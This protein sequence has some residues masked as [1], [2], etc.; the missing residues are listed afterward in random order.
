MSGCCG[1]GA[2]GVGECCVWVGAVGVGAVGGVGVGVGECCGCVGGLGTWV[3]WG[4]GDVWLCGCVGVWVMCVWVQWLRH[5]SSCSVSPT[6]LSF[7]FF[8]FLG[9]FFSQ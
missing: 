1:V 5:Y 3:F 6:F 2:V 9:S 4:R 7:L 8:F